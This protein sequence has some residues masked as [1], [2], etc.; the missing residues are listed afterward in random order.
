MALRAVLVTLVL[1]VAWLGYRVHIRRHPDFYWNRAQA[2]I[3]AENWPVAEIHLRNY[4]ERYPQDARGHLALAE[5]YLQVARQAGQPASYEAQPRA[6]NHLAQAAS[7]R[8]DDLDLQRQA[9]E[10][11]LARRS[12]GNAASFAARVLRNEPE[13][14]DAL[15]VLAWQAVEDQQLLRAEELLER[16]R[17]RPSRHAFQALALTVQNHEL[18]RRSREVQ[19]TMDRAAQLAR[20]MTPEKCRL[21]T[22]YD[23]EAMFRLMA[24]GIRH[25]R[26]VP[27][28]HQRAEAALGA[29][30]NVM[31]AERTDAGTLASQASQIVLVLESNHPLAARD[32]EGRQVRGQLVGM[33]QQLR[34]AAIEGGPAPPLV[35]HQSALAMATGGDHRGALAVLERGLQVTQ[36]LPASRAKERLD[37]HLLAARQLIVLGRYDEAEPH[38][39]FAHR[40][41]DGAGWAQLLSGSIA[42]QRGRVDQAL[43][44]VLEA[45]RLLGSTLLVRMAL[46]DIY[47]RTKNWNDALPVLQSLH[48]ALPELTSEQRAWADRHS[49]SQDNV[50]FG[51]LQAHLAL[52]QLQEARIDLEA[53]RHS[54][55]EPRA[56]A[57]T[58]SHFWRQRRQ[59]EALRML[60]RARRQFPQDKQLLGVQLRILQQSGRDAEGTQ[61]LTDLAKKFPQELSAQLHLAAWQIGH[62]EAQLALDRLTN[63]NA[64]LLQDDEARFAVA[65]YKA[66]AKLTLGLAAEAIAELAP[67]Q[68]DPQRADVVGVLRAAAEM[69]RDN[70]QAAARVLQ[71]AYQRKPESG[72]LGL[73]YGEMA[74]QAGDIDQAIPALTSVL[75]IADLQPRASA[76]LLMALLQA[77]RQQNPQEAEAKIDELI[78][79]YPSQAH[80]LVAKAEVQLRGGQLQ[81]GI[82][83]LD[84]AEL[85]MPENLLWPWLKAS[86][87]LR[88]GN[89]QAALREARRALA[90]APDHLPSL[91]IAARAAM[92]LEEFAATD[93]YC[94]DILRLDP[95]LRQYEL[96]QVDARS[97][98]AAGTDDA[99][100]LEGFVEKQSEVA[101]GY[102]RLGEKRIQSGD[103]AGALEAIRTGQ[104]RV[105]DHKGLLSAEIRL[106]LH[107]GQPD[108]AAQRAAQAAGDTPSAELC[109]A[110]CDA[111]RLAGDLDQAR[112]WG[113]R[114]LEA[115]SD[116]QKAALHMLLGNITLLRASGDN[117]QPA[118]A[119]ARDHFAAALQ[120]R[121]GDLVAGNNLAWLLATELD[122]AEQAVD[123][124]QQVRGKMPLQD[125]PPIFVETMAIVYQKARRPQD[126]EKLLKSALA[127]RPEEPRLLFQYGM[128]LAER[129]QVAEARQALRDAL[130]LGL[131]DDKASQAVRELVKLS[132]DR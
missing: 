92:Q 53:L 102:L 28:A 77:T 9:L 99:S 31:A 88:G 107:A 101:A 104:Q 61:L 127:S 52:G 57:L 56:W 48:N 109:A 112:H 24:S 95:A 29:L 33:A 111:F 20:T 70:A 16:H 105:P 65:A 11:N 32:D 27:V 130:G 13:N 50:L 79:R 126:A 71:E 30:A 86:V 41:Q 22:S 89:P 128:I 120:A 119:E 34:T 51:Q 122:Q 1:A 118:L 40:F 115:A 123:V 94:T 121:P 72:A 93:L 106:L 85:L 76:A 103:L 87:W 97:R 63:L 73:L 3:A 12:L 36:D 69:R 54:P 78:A 5:T 59:D 117:R 125:L 23:L 113:Q 14:A 74:T 129:N 55:L 100:A 132:G 75:E 15:F 35:Y 4:V 26:S 46:A 7:L 2:A 124:V 19:L 17:V 91:T 60:E 47:L 42:L 58:V 18:A 44:H 45:R 131:P 81:A 83:S 68:D 98:L 21:L 66:Q 62:G 25:A 8:P 96:L 82:N 90:I 114:G 110:L 116:D 64:E 39:Q 49:L 108:Q 80:L 43:D 6:L 84:K 38:L 10:G 37:L 67:F